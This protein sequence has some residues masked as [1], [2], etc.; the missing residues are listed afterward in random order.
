MTDE[1]VIYRGRN[2][3]LA[4][5]GAT[6]AQVEVV[7]ALERGEAEPI[8]LTIPRE[9]RLAVNAGEE[10]RIPK[11]VPHAVTVR[12]VEGPDVV[13]ERAVD[14]ATPSARTGLSISLG[15]RLPAL[16]WATA[17]GAADDSSDHWVVVQN[18]GETSATVTIGQGGEAT[19]TVAPHGRLTVP[20]SDAASPEIPS[21]SSPSLTMP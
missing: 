8:R 14:G 1:D 4:D 13:V 2:L 20:A 12:S 16:R 10:S 3:P 17:A 7:L 19:H 5:P 18:P 11:N 6:E 9:S 21:M 15:A